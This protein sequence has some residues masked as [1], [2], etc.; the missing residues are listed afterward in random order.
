VASAFIIEDALYRI[1]DIAAIFRR[2]ESCKSSILVYRG[3]DLT[4]LGF[5]GQ[6]GILDFPNS[7]VALLGQ[8]GQFM[9]EGLHAVMGGAVRIFLRAVLCCYL[10]RLSLAAAE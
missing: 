3:N 6:L 7:L 9:L 10:P 2:R 4:H 8:V 1:E 5:N